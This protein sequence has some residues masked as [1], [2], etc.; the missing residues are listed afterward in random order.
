MIMIEN[1]KDVLR[2]IKKFKK[3]NVNSYNNLGNIYLIN[4][5]EYQVNQDVMSLFIRKLI[6]IM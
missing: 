6:S 4:K 1:E 2:V 3:N 5:K